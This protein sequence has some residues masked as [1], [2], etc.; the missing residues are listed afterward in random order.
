M[1]T[2]INETIKIN[3][4]SDDLYDMLK[5]FLEDNKIDYEELETESYTIDERNEDE[6]YDDW[7][8]TLG[9]RQ[10]EEKREEQIKVN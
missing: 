7:L 4:I 3:H 9:E 1:K 6:K 5:D 8:W 2:Y 10:Y